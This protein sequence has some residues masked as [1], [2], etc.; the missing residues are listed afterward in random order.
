MCWATALHGGWAQCRSSAT[1]LARAAAGEQEQRCNGD[2]DEP[3]KE[4]WE[5]VGEGPLIGVCVHGMDAFQGVES[6]KKMYA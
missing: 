5:V 3:E 4:R 6:R 2:R 1:G